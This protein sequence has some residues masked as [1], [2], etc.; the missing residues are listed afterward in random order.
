MIRAIAATVSAHLHVHYGMA[1]AM[2]LPHVL[3]L[4]LPA[5]APVR[6]QRLKRLAA[7]DDQADDDALVE[8][9]MQFVAYLDLPASLDPRLLPLG[10]FDWDAL[11]QEAFASP[12][13]AGNPRVASLADCRDILARIR[14]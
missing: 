4:N 5:V 8:R 12:S 1:C 6:N 13:V 2:V 10:D 3:H 14:R 11:A 7:L 9:L